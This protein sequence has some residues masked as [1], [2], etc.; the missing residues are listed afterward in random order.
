MTVEIAEQYQNIKPLFAE[1]QI[2]PLA[3]RWRC[4]LLDQDTEYPPF[5]PC[6]FFVVNVFAET[7]DQVIVTAGRFE[8]LLGVDSVR[9]PSLPEQIWLSVTVDGDELLPR[10]ELSR[11]RSVIQG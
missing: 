5:E 3:F 11:Y 10:S 8:V 2:T 6:R 4:I 9:L 1:G 7:R